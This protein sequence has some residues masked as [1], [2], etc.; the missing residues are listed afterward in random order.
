MTG[1]A[2]AFSS[3]ISLG[4]AAPGVP[5]W[6]G[7]RAE[8]R[9]RRA[10]A[11]ARGGASRVLRDPF[12]MYL[13]SSLRRSSAV[14]N[15][16][17]LYSLWD[18]DMKYRC[19]TQSF[20]DVDDLLNAEPEELGAV[21]L[22][23]LMDRANT[24]GQNLLSVGH[25]YMYMFRGP[26]A[27]DYPANRKKDIERALYEAWNWLEREGFLVQPDDLN[28]TYR[29]ISRRGERY[30]TA[31]AVRE[32]RK[33]AAVPR[34]LLHDRIRDKVWPIWLRGDHDIAVLQAFKEVEVAVRD[35]CG[36]PMTK[37]GRDL[38]FEAFKPNVGPLVDPNRPEAEQLAERELFAGAIGG[39]QES[40]K[41]SSRWLHRTR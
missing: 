41:S 16:A 28:N 38:M 33:A 22:E 9:R 1:S 14:F 40:R 34:M 18:A 11:A 4:A 19:I 7:P 32:Y 21:L 25:I 23:D 2:I 35:A 20:P 13:N 24:G 31:L 8:G 26:N 17:R 29:R 10:S 37:F 6:P 30:R 27:L 36:Y 12:A 39:I 5:R 3:V 15:A